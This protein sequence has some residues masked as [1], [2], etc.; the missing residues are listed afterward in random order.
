MPGSS[1]LVSL[2]G[3]L[4][5]LEARIGRNLPGLA[6]AMRWLLDHRPGPGGVRAICHGDF[7]PQNLLFDGRE[8][9]AVLDRPNVLVADPAYDV[10][11]T[12]QEADGNPARSLRCRRSVRTSTHAVAA[13]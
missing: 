7:H 8:I 4:G 12:L 3:H 10:A 13:V 1:A 2:D 9:T 11:A 5:Q 6:P